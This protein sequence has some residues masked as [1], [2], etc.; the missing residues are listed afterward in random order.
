MDAGTQRGR[1]SSQQAE[2]AREGLECGAVGKNV[3]SKR[4]V[5]HDGVQIIGEVVSR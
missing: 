2:A 4:D 3:M 5:A 1:A